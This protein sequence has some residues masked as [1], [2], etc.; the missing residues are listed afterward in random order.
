[1]FSVRVANKG[2][3]L[4]AASRLANTGFRVAV[5]SVICG[6]FVGVA[7]KRVT[8]GR[9]AGLERIGEGSEPRKGVGKNLCAL[10]TPY[11]SM[12]V[13]FVNK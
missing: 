11:Y 5:F 4:D 2:L 12:L 8:A 1:V 7:D 13:L 10:F 6:W 3:M 9:F